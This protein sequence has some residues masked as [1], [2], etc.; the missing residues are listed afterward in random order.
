MFFFVTLLLAQSVHAQGL[1]FTKTLYAYC[2][3]PDALT[4]RQLATN[5]FESQG[6]LVESASASPAIQQHLRKYAL[7]ETIIGLPDDV[8][9]Q[10]YEIRGWPESLRSVARRVPASALL[11]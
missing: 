11:H 5:W 9:Q 7:P 8:L 3:C 4:A 1:G 6:C 2:W 10:E